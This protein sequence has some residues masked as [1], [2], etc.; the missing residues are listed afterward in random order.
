MEWI[1]KVKLLQIPFHPGTIRKEHYL[2]KKIEGRS[3][4]IIHY[5]FPALHVSTEATVYNIIPYIHIY[6]IYNGLLLYFYCLD[7]VVLCASDGRIRP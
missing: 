2:Q 4:F 5:P 1:M 7:R 6:I 3:I